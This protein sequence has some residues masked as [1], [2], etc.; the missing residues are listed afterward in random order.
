MCVNGA[1]VV[2]PSMLHVLP[3]AYRMCSADVK[4]IEVNRTKNKIK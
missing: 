3:I 1:K 2:S 4:Q